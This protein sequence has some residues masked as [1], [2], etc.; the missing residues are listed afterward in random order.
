MR[1]FRHAAARLLAATT[2]G[3]VAPRDWPAPLRP[4]HGCSPQ[5]TEAGHRTGGCGRRLTLPR[6]LAP[7]RP[8]LLVQRTEPQ[9]YSVNI[10]AVAPTSASSSFTMTSEPQRRRRPRPAVAPG[11]AQDAVATVGG[12]HMGL[13]VVGDDRPRRQCRT[14]PGRRPQR[15]RIGTSG[16]RCCCPSSHLWRLS[17]PDPSSARSRASLDHPRSCRAV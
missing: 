8:H 4:S 17:S 6:C 3:W 10:R 1:P 16:Y 12:V 14:R 5:Q 7:S 2:S 13:G 9:G 15:E 11:C